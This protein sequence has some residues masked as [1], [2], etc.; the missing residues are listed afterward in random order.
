[1][2]SQRSHTRF[3]YGDML[4]RILFIGL[5]ISISSCKK[6]FVKLKQAEVHLTDAAQ[7]MGMDSVAANLEI[8]SAFGE[9]R[10]LRISSEAEFSELIDYIEAGQY[11]HYPTIDEIRPSSKFANT[12]Y[13]ESNIFVI[14]L[15]YEG[16]N[17]GEV[18]R[19]KIKVKESTQEIE[20][21][22]KVRVRVGGSSMNSQQ[23]LAFFVVPADKSDY[24]IFGDAKINE[25][26]LTQGGHD[27]TVH[28]TQ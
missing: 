6:S 26:N 24:T 5:I 28:Y 18:K 13:S 27:F 12:N 21:D 23:K 8:S 11:N 10:I 3:R 22:V 15:Y 4:V 7:F 1:M 19:E 16:Q 25:Y 2:I 20:F 14:A 9:S 17:G